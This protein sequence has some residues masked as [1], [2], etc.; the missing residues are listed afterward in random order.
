MPC[1]GQYS[2]VADTRDSKVDVSRSYSA[3][4]LRHAG[5]RSPAGG[6]RM[7]RLVISSPGVVELQ[8]AETPEPGPGEVQ[9]LTRAVGLCGSDLHA[10]AGAHPFSTLPRVPGH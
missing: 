6:D 7:R 2:H 3:G 1:R 10:L 8:E 5:P 4:R 9:V